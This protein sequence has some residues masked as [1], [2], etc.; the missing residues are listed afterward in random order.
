MRDK[1]KEKEQSWWHDI[2]SL[3]ARYPP[4][5]NERLRGVTA[6]LDS[7]GKAIGQLQGGSNRE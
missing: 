3:C 6:A 4:S 1:E 7:F 5:L 2:C